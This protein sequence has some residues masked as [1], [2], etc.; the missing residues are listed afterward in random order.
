MSTD[1]IDFDKVFVKKICVTVNMYAM[2]ALCFKK[3]ATKSK[4][5]RIK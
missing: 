5:G 4:I 1:L 2:K 3:D